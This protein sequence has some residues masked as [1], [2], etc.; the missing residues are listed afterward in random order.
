[1]EVALE[2]PVEMTEDGAP[3]LDTLYREHWWGVYTA[4]YRITG[5]AMDAED[6]LQTVFARLAGRGDGH[7][8][9]ADAGP[10]L[11]RAAI[12]GALDLVRAR[13]AGCAPG[14]DT[15]EP[16]AVADR[17][18][19]AAALRDWLRGALVALHPR[20]A[21]AFALRYVEGYGN[22]DIARL[23]GTSPGA[24][25]VLLHRTRCRLRRALAEGEA[26]ADEWEDPDVAL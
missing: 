13:G 9:R 11:R 10:Y 17:L 14:E 1:M 12:N 2:R 7:G 19:D 23:L 6:V 16:I 3:T 24:V 5:N 8:V 22:A 21:E 25:G 15:R 4:A 18:E 26:P 20:A